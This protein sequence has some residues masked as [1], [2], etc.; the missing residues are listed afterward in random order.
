GNYKCRA[1]NSALGTWHS[2]PRTIS[3]TVAPRDDQTNA[4]SPQIVYPRPARS[5]QHRQR[6][7]SVHMLCLA[8]GNPTSKI[9]WTRY[10]NQ[11]PQKAVI[12][13]DGSLSLD[14]LDLQDQGTYLCHANNG[15]GPEDRINVNIDVM[16]L[17][18]VQMVG[19]VHRHVQE[20]GSMLVRCSMTG[21]PVPDVMWV[22]NGRKLINDGNIFIDGPKIK[23]VSVAK[24]HGGIYQCFAS[25]IGGWSEDFV[26]IQVVPRDVH[27]TTDDSILDGYE[28]E[29]FTIN[30]DLNNGRQ[31]NQGNKEGKLNLKRRNQWNNR[32]IKNENLP[33]GDDLILDNGEEQ[34][35]QEHSDDDEGT[36]IPPSA[37]NVTKISDDS[38]MVTWA[39]PTPTGL[40]ILFYK[41][42][43]R[44]L[45]N[46]RG[47][48]S[49]RW[50]TV[51][52][53]IP[54]HVTSYEVTELKAGNFYKFR[55]AAVYT[56]QD[57]NIGPISKRFLL[58][59]D[60]TMSPPLYPPN[61]TSVER[62]TPMSIQLKW[63]YETTPGI[64]VLGFFINY[65][66][67]TNAGPYTKITVLGN[68]TTSFVVTNLKANISYD[69]KIQGFNLA[70]TS[71]FS[72]VAKRFPTGSVE[73]MSTSLTP[74]PSVSSPEVVRST[75][76]MSLKDFH[77]YLILGG[78]LTA[79]LIIVIICYIVYSCKNKQHQVSR[80]PS[81]YE[82]T[83]LHIHRETS[84]YRLPQNHSTAESTNGYLPHQEKQ[85]AHEIAEK[86]SIESSLV[87]NNNAHGFASRKQEI[88]PEDGQT[89][90][91][92]TP[93]QTNITLDR[94]KQNSDCNT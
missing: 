42:Q 45:K 86:I 23:I 28:E 30:H 37:P 56:N 24:K 50:K 47:G 38:V 3:L 91:H 21:H 67:A 16:E 81:M 5:P 51:E 48:R 26:L 65:R 60:P 17:P 13:P 72:T 59:K 10:G 68:D 92:H 54:S 36:M 20:G 19:D 7:S 61:V 66:E 46:N 94:R 89:S 8:S 29:D 87:D 39:A 90:V 43:Y 77:L 33:K 41:V 31:N 69:F 62:L 93:S 88:V 82:D 44:E 14:D 58:E 83:S 25:N 84:I 80:A 55:I 53:D 11:L 57:N 22:F 12:G 32:R 34:R 64:E 52:E 9:S 49:G 76:D 75:T 1:H 15:V 27:L 71:D 35:I 79:L 4:T 2:S 6:G 74:P 78:L 40:S 70:G 63:T 85:I 73:V 18:T